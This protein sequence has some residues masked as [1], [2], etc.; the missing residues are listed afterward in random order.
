[1]TLQ[2]FLSGTVRHATEMWKHVRRLVHQQRDLLTAEA[3][4]ALD[5]A[6]DQTRVAID[7]HAG[8]EALDK[9]IAELEK[10]AHKWLKTHP[11]PAWR[12]NI[13]VLL[14]AIAVAMAVR[15]FFLQPFK[16]PTRSI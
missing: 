7:S 14:V 11:N 10:V 12:E 3:L 6:L 5:A 13:E 15:T 8:K 2:W 9:Q 1:M 4:E 16:I